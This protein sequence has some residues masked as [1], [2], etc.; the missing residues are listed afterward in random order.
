MP[1]A[2]W[3]AALYIDLFTNTDKWNSLPPAYKS[4]VRMAADM[5]NMWMTAKYDAAI[6]SPA[7]KKLVAEGTQLRVFPQPVM[8]ACLKASN[9]VYAEISATNA[10]FKKIGKTSKP[11][12]T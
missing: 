3:K 8:E 6:F 10:D 11:S 12:A 2:R 1:P 4:I 9:E 5:T 7:L